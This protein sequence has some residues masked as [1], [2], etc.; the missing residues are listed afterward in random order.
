MLVDQDLIRILGFFFGQVCL[1]F[2]TKCRSDFI[3]GILNF[4][5]VVIGKKVSG[6]RVGLL[7][8]N[9]WKSKQIEFNFFIK[10]FS[11]N[12]FNWVLSVLNIF[13]Q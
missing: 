11:F 9:D 7:K 8:F 13:E 3:F 10:L 2:F 6:M 12:Y 5:W 4:L 1:V